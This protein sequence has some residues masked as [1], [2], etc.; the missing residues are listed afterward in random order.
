MW[1]LWKAE[2]Q[3]YACPFISSSPFWFLFFLTI[4]L[5]GEGRFWTLFLR[6]K[7]QCQLS[8][9][10]LDYLSISNLA[11][12]WFSF[13]AF[14]WDGL[15]IIEWKYVAKWSGM[16]VFKFKTTNFFFFSIL[17][18]KIKSSFFFFFINYIELISH[19]PAFFFIFYFKYD[20]RLEL[21]EMTS[22]KF[23][24]NLHSSF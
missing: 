23:S 15:P 10:T 5:L 3:C 13:L 20:Y 21:I 11:W 12:V 6:W 9:K 16:G 18:M 24:F 22:T 14:T 19:T 1:E 4:Q 17:P 8:Y 7:H 2:L